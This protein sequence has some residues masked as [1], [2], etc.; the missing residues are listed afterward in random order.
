MSFVACLVQ[1]KYLESEESRIPESVS[2]PLEG[3]D[4]VVGTLQ[5]PAEMGQSYHASSPSR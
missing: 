4:L 5:G 2:L 1:G 3:F